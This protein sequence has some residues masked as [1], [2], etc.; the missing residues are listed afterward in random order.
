MRGSSQQALPNGPSL[1]LRDVFANRD[2]SIS[3]IAERTGLPQS[4]VSESVASLAK[5]GL[6]QT[7]V[8]SA[9]KR[10]TL[11]RV[12]AEHRRT[13]ARKGATP[14]DTALARALGDRADELDEVAALLER[15]FE[16]LVP[17]AS[18]PVI[19]QIRPVA[20]RAGG[21]DA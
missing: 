2:S 13:V 14:I 4:Y 6:V 1:V 16:R 3:Q 8:D 12:T 19:E 5:E 17:A 15:L 9:D 10:R 11:V 21:R 20:R 7:R 18:G